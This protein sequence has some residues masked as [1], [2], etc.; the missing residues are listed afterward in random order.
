V[1]TGG[2]ALCP[3]N[4]YRHPVNKSKGRFLLVEVEKK[5]TDDL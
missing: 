1:K 4:D 5:E 2:V 3:H